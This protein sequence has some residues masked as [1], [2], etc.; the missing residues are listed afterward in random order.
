MTINNNLVN[1]SGAKI[2]SISFID[3][4]IVLFEFRKLRGG[5]DM[6]FF[7]KKISDDDWSKNL[8][9]SLLFGGLRTISKRYDESL[10]I[11]YELVNLELQ[12]IRPNFQ[13]VRQ[14]LASALRR[15]GTRKN[16]YWNLLAGGDV[17]LYDNRSKTAAK[18]YREAKRLNK[19]SA[20]ATLK[21]DIALSKNN[22]RAM[23][24]V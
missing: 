8:D 4:S 12:K 15:S 5:P 14:L 24:R 9:S 19:S 18:Y 20:L 7:G 13:R 16:S 6:A 3:D 10:Q 21:L 11:G 1:I 2:F 17:A 22:K 23:N